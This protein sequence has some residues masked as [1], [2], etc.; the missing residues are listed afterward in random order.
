MDS[1][2]LADHWTAWAQLGMLGAMSPPKAA[3][4]SL[5]Y[6]PEFVLVAAVVAYGIFF[7]FSWNA[8]HQATVQWFADRPI[9]Q[10]PLVNVVIVS[11]LG[12]I[13]VMAVLASI[14]RIERVVE[15]HRLRKRLREMQEENA[16][17]RN[18]PEEPP[19]QRPAP[20]RT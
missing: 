18:V 11:F 3:P 2:L 13:A 4:S 12:G 14:G 10:T 9:V 8:S 6:V 17:L 19:A 5:R 15:I 16:R 20:P 1:G 7:A